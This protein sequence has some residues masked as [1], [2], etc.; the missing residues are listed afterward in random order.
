MLY[1]P[2]NGDTITNGIEAL[3][4]REDRS[5]VAFLARYVLISKAICILI[6][7][8]DIVIVRLIPEL[9]CRAKNI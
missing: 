6:Y 8:F 3:R 7:L 2:H 1:R 4:L 9:I 5:I